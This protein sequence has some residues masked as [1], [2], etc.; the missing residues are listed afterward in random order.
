MN[1][2]RITM[3]LLFI[4]SFTYGQYKPNWVFVAGLTAA[5][6][7]HGLDQTLTY[8]QYKFNAK[9]PGLANKPFWN[10]QQLWDKTPLILG[11]R[12][13]AK[14]ILATGTQALCLGSGIVLVL[15]KKKKL[16]YYLYDL[17]LGGIGYTVGNYV[18]YDLLFK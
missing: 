7:S 5:G 2:I 4:S 10:N 16:Q 12:P 14:H 13:N 3:L 6:A 18:T 17:V 9:F 1:K 11:Y 15:G 8:H